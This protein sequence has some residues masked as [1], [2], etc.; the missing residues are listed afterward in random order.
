VETSKAGDEAAQVGEF[1]AQLVAAQSALERFQRESKDALAKAE[2]QWK[3]DEAVRFT[4]FEAEWR[5]RIAKAEAGADSAQPNSDGRDAEIAE[6]KATIETLKAERVAQAPVAPASG[7]GELRSLREK[8]ATLE[9][10]LIKAN[11]SAE[12]ERLRWQREAQAAI[13]KAEKD[14]RAKE[15]ARRFASEAAVRKESADALA[16]ATA[17]YEAAEAALAQIRV[18]SGKDD[19]VRGE[20]ELAATRSALIAREE[21]LAHIRAQLEAHS[22]DDD[23]PAVA[24]AAR[25]STQRYIRDAVVAASIGVAVVIAYPIVS[26]MLQAPAVVTAPAVKRIEPPPP[27]P[28]AAPKTGRVSEDAKLRGGPSKSTG[29]V[30]TL[31]R[32]TSVVVLEERSD[33][34]LVRIEGA[35][36]KAGA[37]EG[38]VSAPLLKLDAAGAPAR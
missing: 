24:A 38:W 6:L 14:F 4:A 20:L 5:D 15:T 36:A 31:A 19:T 33:W 9:A 29:V 17:R 3:V 32:G 12:E 16:Q 18:R 7:D 22:S 2:A 23:A 21:E 37:R 34:T 30:A 26:S 13:S 28:P 35:S 11:K 25:P 10:K 27:P 8:A 1:R